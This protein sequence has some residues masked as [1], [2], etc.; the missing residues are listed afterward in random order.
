[1]RSPGR[2]LTA[3]IKG[4][5]R[6]SPV[7]IR[8]GITRMNETYL[9]K[10]FHE[11]KR[12]FFVVGGF[13]ALTIFSN[14]IK[15]EMTPLFLWG[16]YSE[17]EKPVKTY[18][19]LELRVNGDSLIDHSSGLPDNTRFFLSS[20]VQLY[21]EIKENG[22]KDPN[23][24]FFQKKVSAEQN[25]AQTLATKVFNDSSGMEKFPKWYAAYLSRSLGIPVT[26]YTIRE[27]HLHFSTDMKPIADSNNLL[28]QWP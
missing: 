20:P 8:T 19:V 17:K 3:R 16:M 27:I 9:G 25:S 7:G 24:S 22:Q 2:Y 5:F 28:L 6:D 11:D 10:L 15:L 23:L 26:K 13:I 21:K 14:T 4:Y 18:T 12:L 1:M